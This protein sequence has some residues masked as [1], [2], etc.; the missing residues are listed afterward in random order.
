MTYEN[1]ESELGTMTEELAGLCLQNKV[2]LN[3][4]GEMFQTTLGTLCKDPGSMLAA[5]FSGP[6]GE[7]PD[8]KDGTYFIDRDGK[9]F[10]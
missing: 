1:R 10:R 7:M 6:F 8:E 9:L 3:V 5:M 2:K 4:G